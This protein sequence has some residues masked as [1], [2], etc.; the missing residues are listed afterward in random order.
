MCCDGSANDV[1]FNKIVTKL[2]N[3]IGSWSTR[4]SSL[5]GKVLIVNTLISSLFVYS[6]TMML[7]LAQAQ[8]SKIDQKIH[9]YLWNN[10]K[11]G[12]INMKTLKLRKEDGGLRLVNLKAKQDSINVQ[13]IFRLEPDLMSCLYDVLGVTVLKGNLWKCNLSPKECLFGREYWG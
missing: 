1:N 6:M 3:V 11:C 12:R 2:D 9:M 13:N 10:K 8:L 5:S 7:D 4:S